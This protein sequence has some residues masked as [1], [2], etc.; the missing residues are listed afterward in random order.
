MKYA[1][2]AAGFIAIVVGPSSNPIITVVGVVLNL[3]VAIYQFLEDQK[4]E[5]L[6]KERAF[7]FSPED[8]LIEHQEGV[9]VSAKLVIPPGVH[10]YGENV[11]VRIE[12]TENKRWDLAESKIEGGRITITFAPNNFPCRGIGLIVY[13]SARG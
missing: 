12:Q 11:L 9:P 13:I 10:G 5:K 3:G 6:I 1:I 8:W 4:N 7:P 2:F